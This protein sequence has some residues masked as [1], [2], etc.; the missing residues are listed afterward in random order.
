MGTAEALTISEISFES[1]GYGSGGEVFSR[2][3]SRDTSLET[4]VIRVLVGRRSARPTIVECNGA[5]AAHLIRF[6]VS[7]S[8]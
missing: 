4:G 2:F 3:D 7:L 1:Q 8:N 6:A 5:M